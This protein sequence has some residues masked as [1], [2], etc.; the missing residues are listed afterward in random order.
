M[1]RPKHKPTEIIPQFMH[2]PANCKMPVCPKCSIPAYQRDADNNPMYTL[3][4][5][6]EVLRLTGP[7]QSSAI[8]QCPQCNQQ[9][10]SPTLGTKIKEAKAR[11][12]KC[13]FPKT[14]SE[15]TNKTTLNSK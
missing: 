6:C 2:I 4:V 1:A 12:Q 14:N 5:R 3:E 10:Y 15:N 9:Y 7:D 8:I 11:S 13:N